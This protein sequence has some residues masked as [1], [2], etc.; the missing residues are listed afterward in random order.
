MTMLRG[1]AARMWFPVLL[2]A[3]WQLIANAKIY[4]D[5]VLPGP[6][7]VAMRAVKD[8][9]DGYLPLQIGAS[10]YRQIIGFLLSV[11]VGLPLGLLIGMSRPL[12]TAVLPTLQLLYPIP[13]IAWVPL[14]ILWFGIGEASIIFVVFFSAIWALLFNTIAGVSAIRP[15]HR[16]AAAAL[17]LTP[18]MTFRYLYLPGAMPFIIG[19]LRLAYG[20]SWRVIVGAEI[21]SASTGLGFMINNARSQLVGSEVILGMVVIGLLGYVVEKILFDAIEKVTIRRWA[22][23]VPT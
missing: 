13:G 11:L 15:V 8:I 19:G 22:M 12:R 20:T 7:A 21:I 3:I 16:R 1:A 6:N 2:I 18:L 14:A 4:P 5:Y 9:S 10:L 23:T 17:S